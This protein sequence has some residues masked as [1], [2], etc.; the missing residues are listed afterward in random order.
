MTVSILKQKVHAA[1]EYWLAEQ[2]DVLV[3]HEVSNYQQIRPMSFQ[4]GNN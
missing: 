1:F 2:M 3:S 4:L